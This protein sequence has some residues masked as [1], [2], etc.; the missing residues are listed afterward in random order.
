MGKVLTVGSYRRLNAV[1]STGVTS[2]SSFSVPE[3]SPIVSPTPEVVISAIRSSPY[4]CPYNAQ[5]GDVVYLCDSGVVDLADA[6]T[7]SKQPIVGIISEKPTPTTA[8]VTYKGEVEVFSDLIPGQRYYLGT[9]PGKFD[10]TPPTGPGT[11]EQ[12]LGFARSATVLVVV[13][14]YD[15]TV[16]A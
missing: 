5:I 8:I 1:P 4:A 14:N 15:I 16:N 9:T 3:A 10:T 6:L 12:N 2:A 13:I 7:E 11:I